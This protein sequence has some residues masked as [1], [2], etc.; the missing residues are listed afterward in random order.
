MTLRRALIAAVLSLA[1]AGVSA[2]DGEIGRVPMKAFQMGV[3]AIQKKDYDQARKS[4]TEVISV[5]ATNSTALYYLAVCDA[6][7][8]NPKGAASYVTRAVEAGFP[9]RDYLAEDPY[10][11][12]ARKDEAY[13]KSVTALLER[14]RRR[15]EGIVEGLDFDYELQDP[16]GKKH[17][18]A[19]H[20]GKV[21]I[22]LY[23][24]VRK[25]ECLEAAI[26]V[27]R[28]A[29][30]SERPV[31]VI[32]FFTVA[33]KDLDDQNRLLEEYQDLY[34]FN[35]PGVVVNEAIRA[36]VKPFREYPTA[37]FLDPAGVPRRIVEGVPQTGAF[38][39]YRGAIEKT[40]EAAE[41]AKQK[42]KPSSG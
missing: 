41:N 35:F 18:P 13:R 10:L 19:D 16:K 31:S 14:Y 6:N 1:T 25:V 8:G 4:F 20:R 7:Q 42:P 15:D 40:F 29:G 5:H 11:A 9:S 3:Q 12:E 26:H 23:L 32:G 24:D 21:L 28:A 22:V 17:K 2:Q 27:M 33:G 38:D 36:K 37:L 39:A 34:R 30:N